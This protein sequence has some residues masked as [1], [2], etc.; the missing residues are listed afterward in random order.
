MCDEDNYYGYPRESDWY[1]TSGQCDACG[2][3]RTLRC[4]VGECT[5]WD[6]P[7]VDHE[8]YLAQYDDDPNPYHG[9]YSED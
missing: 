1:G 8:S 3:T 6:E 4:A 2:R 9:T 7:E 5:T